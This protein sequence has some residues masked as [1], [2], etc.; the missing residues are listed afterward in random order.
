[1]NQSSVLSPYHSYH[2]DNSSQSYS[3]AAHRDKAHAGHDEADDAGILAKYATY[4]DKDGKQSLLEGA[5]NE[6]SMP[7][8]RAGLMGPDGGAMDNAGGG[9]W[10]G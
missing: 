6:R 5:R 9:W 10:G 4:S 7:R 2:S 8:A 1:M 3:I